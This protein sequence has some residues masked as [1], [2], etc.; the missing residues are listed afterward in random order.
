[1]QK[2]VEPVSRQKKGEILTAQDAVARL[3]EEEKKKDEKK[4]VSAK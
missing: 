1:M 3:Q 2:N 4:T